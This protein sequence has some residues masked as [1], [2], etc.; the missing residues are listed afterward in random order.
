MKCYL[1]RI[2]QALVEGWQGGSE[3]EALAAEP[4][5]YLS[6]IPGTCTAEEEKQS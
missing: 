6:S 5:R 1:A 3:R 4:D 2:S